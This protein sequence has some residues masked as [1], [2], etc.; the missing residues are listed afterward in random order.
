V[1]VGDGR[2]AVERVQSDRPDIV[3]ADVAMPG[4]DGYEV[5]AFIR[6]DPRLA[7]IPVVLLAGAFEPLDENRARSVACDAVLVKPFEPQTVIDRVKELLAGD[8]PRAGRPR[9]AADIPEAPAVAPHP[10]PGGDTDRSSQPAIAAK[11]KAVGDRLEDYFDRLDAAFANIG[12]PPSGPGPGIEED[13]ASGIAELDQLSTE[14]GHAALD[15]VASWDPDIPA[16]FTPAGQPHLANV[17][18]SLLAAEE[19]GYAA[20]MDALAV[21]PPPAPAII[22]E[23]TIEEIVRRVVARM[24]DDSMRQL[25]AETAERLV[26]DEIDRIKGL[27]QPPAGQ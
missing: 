9:A 16:G 1:A 12:A 19:E 23:D 13:L 25:V 14:H 18:A 10:A 17:F 5:A 11:D 26:R 2:Q 15:S 20:P 8:R 21:A 3:L 22:S 7:G 27:A 4:L 24:A 6:N